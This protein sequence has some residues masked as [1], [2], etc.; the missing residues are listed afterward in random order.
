MDTKIAKRGPKK[1]GTITAVDCSPLP[2]A[3]PTQL[4]PLLCNP[5]MWWGSFL[6][7]K[8][9]KWEREQGGGGIEGPQTWEAVLWSPVPSPPQLEVSKD[10]IQLTLPT[11][12]LPFWESVYWETLSER[13]FPTTSCC[14]FRGL[15]SQSFCSFFPI[16]SFAAEN[17]T[18]PSS[19]LWLSKSYY[20]SETETYT[21]SQYEWWGVQANPF[22]ALMNTVQ[23][24]VQSKGQMDSYSKWFETYVKIQEMQ[25][26]E[27]PGV[28]YTSITLS[29]HNKNL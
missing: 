11:H 21:G 13:G 2:A 24:E 20:S 9:W 22:S 27:T 5:L 19:Q 18:Q 29:L 6:Q 8:S 17:Y 14:N 3:S 4:S 16:L 10:H 1:R 26:L 25:K 7:G 12:Q 23:P 28:V 15:N